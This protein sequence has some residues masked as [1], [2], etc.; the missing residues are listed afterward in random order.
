V[1]GSVENEG[2]EEGLG[3]DLSRRSKR[4]KKAS[5]ETMEKDG[6]PGSIGGAGIASQPLRPGEAVMGAQFAGQERFMVLRRRP[7]Q[8]NRP[9]ENVAVS[10]RRS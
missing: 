5:R 10:R 3:D 2:N 4:L 8:A 7:R 1:N 6:Q 9:Q